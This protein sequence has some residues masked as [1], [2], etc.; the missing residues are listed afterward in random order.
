MTTAPGRAGTARGTGGAL[1]PGEE[2]GRHHLPTVRWLAWAYLAVAAA[3]VPWTVY[4]AV[5]LPHR[6]L[7]LHY[8]NTWVGFD[9]VLVVVMA[10]IGWFAARRDPRVVLSA[11]VGA[12]MLA[13][14][15]WFDVTTSAPGAAHVQALLSAGLLELPGALLCSLLARHG[16]R[17]LTTRRA[18]PPAE[19]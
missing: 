6:S 14:D 15:A 5:T 1:P 9:V 7:S 12:T 17:V 2:P 11:A 13:A 19:G 4:L 10:R 16:L 3:L 8:R 18:G